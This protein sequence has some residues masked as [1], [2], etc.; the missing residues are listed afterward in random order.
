MK[1]LYKI[2]FI[3]FFALSVFGFSACNSEATGTNKVIEK[4][5]SAPI[6]KYPGKPQPPVDM[7]YNFI[8]KKS[9]AVG[10]SVD[11]QLTFKSKMAVDGLDIQLSVDSGLTLLNSADHY[12]L[13]VQSKGDKSV[14]DLKVS[15]DADGYYYIYVTAT[16]VTGG[17]RQSR[18]F[19]I[20]V[21]VGDVDTQ[22]YMKPAGVVQEDPTGQKIISM[23]ASKPR[24]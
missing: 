22:K 12:S 6:S 17:T 5:S 8:T 14:L 15:P 4:S 3:L 9:F 19:T 21:N 7:K 20:P 24:N 13:G 11:I 10:E 1:Y 2:K 23:P 16:L 18:S